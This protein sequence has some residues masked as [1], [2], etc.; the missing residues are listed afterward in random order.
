MVAAVLR[1]SA[2]SSRGLVYWDEAKFA[3]EGM[4]LEHGL[5]AMVELH[6][7]LPAGKAVGTAKPAHALFIA[8]A[9]LVAGVHDY[10]SLYLD[11]A[12]S[13][14]AVLV[15]YLIARRLFDAPVALVAA[16]L[17]ATSEYDVI[18]ARSALS[19]S[20]ANL[21]LLLAVAIWAH[22]SGAR[23]GEFSR[24][25]ALSARPALAS[26]VLA[27]L[28]FST[29]Y[30]LIVYAA[31]LIL[32]DMTLVYRRAGIRQSGWRLGGWLAGL[33][34]VPVAWEVIGILAAHGGF[35]L[36][37]GEID[38]LPSSYFQEVW[39]QLHEGKQSVFHFSPLSYAQWWVVR[40]GW[41][42]TVVLVAGLSLAAVR[43]TFRWLAA[44]AFVVLPYGL[45]IFA[46]FYVPR[47]LSPSLPFDAILMAAALLELLRRFGRFALPAVLI[48]SLL[49]GGIGALMSW[50]L[51]AER[52]GFVLAARY[53]EKHGAG[54]ALTSTEIM[55]FYLRGPGRY[56]AAPAL[57]FTLRGLAAYRRK[58]Y[59]LA[60]IDRH[61]ESPV[62]PAILARAP[63]AARFTAL[64]PLH[65]GESL[66][67]SENSDPPN[68]DEPVEFVTVYQLDRMRLPQ[69]S[70]ARV[71]PCKLDNVT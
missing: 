42:A 68:A 61:H 51:T 44:A 54:R 24:R 3:L 23:D 17:L 46:P 65:I 37:R 39:Y 49:L 5:R 27:G 48:A 8:L 43:R 18:Y 25:A 33:A 38:R 62:V 15:L 9:Y 29:N 67:S 47:N 2:L 13:T 58:G 31:I 36:F 34:A 70:A 32:L 7:V 69:V 21:L 30:R 40:Q 26:G 66:I 59:D 57:P 14:L 6:A 16:L 1:F 52:S 10:S 22:G 71:P 60:V 11:A 55:V 50:R 63:V 19:E 56:C 41:P 35:T 64:G 20:D 4:R 28:A 53:V 12:A 45:Y